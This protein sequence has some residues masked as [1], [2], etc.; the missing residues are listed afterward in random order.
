M[1]NVSKK[2]DTSSWK[3]NP[4]H[5]VIILEEKKHKENKMSPTAVFFLPSS[6]MPV[7]SITKCIAWAE[8]QEQESQDLVV[9]SATLILTLKIKWS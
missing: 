4:K 3:C 2:D 9:W 8:F 1:V 7:P 6:H 5:P